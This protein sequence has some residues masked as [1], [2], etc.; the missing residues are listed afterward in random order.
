MMVHL[1]G[2]FA[3]RGHRVDLVLGRQRGHFLDAIPRTVRCVELRGASALGALRAAA[4]DPATA[5]R[6]APADLGCSPPWV[7]GRAPAPARYLRQERPEALLSAL[8]YSNLTALWA[9]RLAGVP[10]RLVVSERNTL[11]VQAA[12][13]RRRRERMLPA[14]VRHFYPEADAVI[15]VSAG[16]ADDLARASGI[17]RDRIQVT[18]N[19]VVTP[20]LA[21]Q[22]RAPL[23][24][25][26]FE[27][28]WPPVVLGVG[29]LKPQKDFPT[30]L[31]A[32]ARLRSTRPA[33]LVILGEG[34]ERRRLETLVRELGIGAHV[35]L[36][37][38]VDN[39]FRYMGRA[40]VFALASA[41][42]G[43][44]G[45]LIQAM[46]C[47]CAVVSTDCPSG[48]AEI[49][50]GGEHGPLVPVGDDAAL[51]GAIGR[52]LDAPPDPAA[53]RARADAF[54]MDRVADRYLAVLIDAARGGD[55][56]DPES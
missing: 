6:L 47:G 23:D 33:R 18:Y 42:E 22:A 34:P 11:S 40:A 31:R 3:E 37:G 4:R 44:P 5:R 56:S 27:P 50:E 7:L 21:E 19:P 16:V 32:F 45:V 20:D 46:A 17:A 55:G 29:K 14:L 51:A 12:R 8:N 41:W 39:P 38:F 26:W 43:L 1:A 49:L 9:R 48:P 30:L 24:C 25:D 52:L 10:L 53:L 35:A 15:A 54:A 28:G 13:D 2:A 36:P